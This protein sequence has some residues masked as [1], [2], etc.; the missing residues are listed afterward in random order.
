[1]SPTA[2]EPI[3][4]IDRLVKEFQP[5]RRAVDELSLE[6]FEGEIFGFL[7][8]NG[9]GKTSTLKIL[10]T[11][12]K[13]TSGAAVVAGFDV[14]SQPDAVRAAIGYVGQQPGVD[15]ALTGRENL[16]LQGHLYHLSKADILRRTDD[17]LA[18]FALTNEADWRVG[19]Y[20]GGMKRKLDIAMAMIHQPKVLFLDEPTL[21]L[22][23]QSR[24]ALWQHITQLNKAHHM[25]IFLT[26]HYLEEAD[27]LSHRLAIVDQG[28]IRA[29]GTA[30]AL[31]DTLAGDGIHLTFEEEFGSQE[32]AQ[33]REGGMAREVIQE[34][35][36]LHLYLENG[37]GALPKLLQLLEQ[38]KVPVRTVALSR[39]S[40]D[41]VFLKY[42]GHSLGK[43]EESS[44]GGNPWWPGG[45]G[46]DWQKWQKKWQKSGETGKPAEGESEAKPS[47]GWS[48]GEPSQGQGGDQDWSKWAKQ[49]EKK[50]E[51]APA[52][53]ESKPDEAEK[54]GKPSWPNKW[55]EGS[56]SEKSEKSEKK[57]WEKSDW[58]K[59][60]GKG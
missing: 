16:H 58:N 4:R 14:V 55:S 56:D 12:S 6:V 30:D 53:P 25:T 39:P 41:D 2:A 28:K 52:T 32:L 57:E 38:L 47:E 59:W 21:G 22:D 60:G 36:E 29:L 27:R 48:S 15:M 9:A 17:L 19:G 40:L 37:K 8:P 50:G 24:N 23:P 33:I 35:K 20:S 45:G 1:M 51:E 13:P 10:T 31:K 34:G 11:L 5:D 54:E 44:S 42:T 49:W 7:G 18:L 46:G 26:T 3:I 43:G